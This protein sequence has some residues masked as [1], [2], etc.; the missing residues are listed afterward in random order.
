MGKL[1]KHLI[2]AQNAMARQSQV[3]CSGR[4]RFTVIAPELLRVEVADSLDFNFEPTQIVWNRDL[5]AY[6]FEIDFEETHTIIKTSAATFYFNMKKEKVDKVVIDGESI[7][8]YKHNLKGTAR[9]LDGTNGRAKY[10]NGVVGRYG[11]AVLEDNS[12]ILGS[13]GMVKARKPQK[14]HYI[15]ATK[16]PQRALELLYSITGKPPMIPR[17]AIGN[18]WSRYYAYEQQE[19]LDL[20]DRFKKEGIKFTIATVDMDWHVTDVK[21]EFG[22]KGIEGIYA[23][24]VGW[25]GYTWNKHLFPD[26]KQ[27]LKDLKARNLHTTL[28]LHPAAGV[29]WFE[30]QYED[31]AKAVGIDPETKKTAKFDIT[32]E[33]FLNAYFKYLHRPYEEDG[34]AFWWIDWQQ[35]TKSKLKGYDPLWACNHYHYLDNAYLGKR[36]MILSRYAGIGSHRYPVGFSGDTIV[37]WKSLDLQPDFTARA[38]NVGFTT[39]SHDICGHMLGYP[40]NDELYLRW[41]QFGVFSP[42]C[43]L[44]STKE[45][46]IFFPSM[47]KEPWNHPSVYEDA[48][49]Y[50]N[51]RHA[52]IPYIYTA[53]YENYK[54]S[55][56]ICKP[57]YYDYPADNVAYKIKNQYAFGSELVVCPITSKVNDTK[58]AF[59]DIWVPEGEKYID[60]FTGEE[61]ES[62]YHRIGKELKDMPVYARAG[63]IIPMAI[64]EYNEWDNPENM[65]IKI[66]PGNNVYSLYED[67]SVNQDY[68]EGKNVITDFEIKDEEGFLTFE[69]RKAKGD[70]SLIPKIRNYK[71]EIH[72]LENY[73]LES[74]TINGKEAKVEIEGSFINLEGVESSKGA[75]LVLKLKESENNGAM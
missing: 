73:Q 17:Y 21:K 45:R 5:G 8:P 6:P 15:F 40:K 10:D 48:V 3:Y 19:Y 41:I 56:P 62:G 35:G 27:F 53:Y 44:H 24:F 7:D 43:R 23:I 14:D 4:H 54:N 59:R 32:D 52:L 16:Q 72:N 29:R 34:V 36:P 70:L 64:T 46:G 22:F 13:D 68:L 50:L 2:V 47:S 37:T 49:R 57:M 61:F 31:M 67:A 75:K 39:W 33:N 66:Y 20:M 25:T 58:K 28:N 65:H 1:D 60:F 63:S 9:T 71:L 38:S 30:D 51:L 18:W 42:I 74:V 12:L 69:I 11:A 55:V 26:Y